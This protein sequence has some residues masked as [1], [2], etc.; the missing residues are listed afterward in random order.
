MFIRL[1][2]YVFFSYRGDRYGA[3]E[4]PS[5]VEYADSA[6]R[7]VDSQFR[8]SITHSS[9][10]CGGRGHEF[11]FQQ[12]SVGSALLSRHDDPR[13]RAAHSAHEPGNV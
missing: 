12:F 4:L 13:H 8:A 7:R 11:P 2:G 5:R 3:K 9:S 1:V 10:V 6:H